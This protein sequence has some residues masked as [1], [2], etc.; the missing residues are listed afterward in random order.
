MPSEVVSAVRSNRPLPDPKLNTLVVL[1]KEMVSKRGYVG[2]QAIENFLAAGYRKDQI[3]E[4]LIGVALKTVSNYYGRAFLAN[5]DL[6]KRLQLG[7]ALNEPDQQT[8]Y[9]GDAKGYT[10]YPFHS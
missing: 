3:L 8:F 4:V 7:S 1:A 6:P 9:G 2:A 10:D 5:P